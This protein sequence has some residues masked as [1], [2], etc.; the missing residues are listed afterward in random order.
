MQD[1]LSLKQVS[2]LFHSKS[3]ILFSIKSCYSFIKTDRLC[4]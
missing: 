2:P 1:I 3:N 4:I